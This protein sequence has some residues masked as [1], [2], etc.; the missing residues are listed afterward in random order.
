MKNFILN[1]L[2]FLLFLGFPTCLMA[3]APYLGRVA[4]FALFTTAGAFSNIGNSA[5]TGDIGTNVGALT[6]FPPGTVSGSIHVADSVTTLAATN[7]GTAFASLSSL[8]CDSTLGA[9]LGNGQ[10]LTPKVY[11]I[12]TLATLN[13]NL[14]LNA[15]GNPNAVFV[16]KVNGA[17]S[18]GISSRI[19]LINAANFNNVYWFVNGAFTLADSSS[20]KG[21]LI[22]NGAINL[23]QKSAIMGRGLTT[24][25]AISIQ[26][27]SNV[28]PVQLTHFSLNCTNSQI[29]FNWSSASEKNNRY[30]SLEASADQ[31]NWVVLAQ[32]KGAGNS[33]TLKNYAFAY[34]NPNAAY[35]YFRLKQTDTD[36]SFTYSE[37]LGTCTSEEALL[38]NALYPNPSTGII[39][40]NIPGSS[41]AGTIS[42][43][44]MLGTLVY[45]SDNLQNSINLSAQAN[46]FYFVN[47]HTAQQNLVVKVLI[48]HN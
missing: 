43:Y 39:N 47:L 25:G 4:T 31:R 6:G 22:A 7:L 18:T 29:D 19:L 24:A 21:T 38:P 44:N 26:N 30:F 48:K 20:F 12:T 34:T 45:Q 14:T 2:V 3:Q 41:P 37:T 15:M 28:L 32:I 13:G 35:T 10:E 33:S 42:V 11:C 23:M 46:G 1:R 27:T 9:T 17:L 40:I 5:I 36:G 16:I 8:T